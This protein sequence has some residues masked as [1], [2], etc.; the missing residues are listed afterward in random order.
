MLLQ[1]VRGGNV[2]TGNPADVADDAGGS[3]LAAFAVL[4]AEFDQLGF[5]PF[6]SFIVAKDA[7]LVA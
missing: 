6:S 3:A 7:D 5:A 1:T 4:A 2:G